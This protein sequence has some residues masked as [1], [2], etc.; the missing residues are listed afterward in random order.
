[1]RLVELE[2]ELKRVERRPDTWTIRKDDGSS[3]QV[4]G[5]RTYYVPV[6][7]IAEADGI[8]FLCPKCFRD[9]GNS[10]VGT[11]WVACWRPKMPQ[12]DYLTGPGRWE[13]VGTDFNNLSLVANPTSVQIEGGCN[14]HFTVSNG[15][16]IWNG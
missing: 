9:H 2:P 15:E 4:S 12:A 10:N 16:I 13:L 5:L 1:M 8:W 7:T 3:E 14:A 6:A 11:H